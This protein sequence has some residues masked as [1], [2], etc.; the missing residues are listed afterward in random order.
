ML[1]NF[2]AFALMFGLFLSGFALFA[3]RRFTIH[4]HPFGPKEVGYLYAYSGL[5]GV[6][7]Q[8]GL[9]GRLVK[10]FGEE[11]LTLTGYVCA[12]AGFIGL[13]F[14][15]PLAA[16]LLVFSFTA[17]GNSVLRPCLTALVTHRS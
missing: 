11:R 8:G 3:E 4:G 10:R 6:F 12:A 16:L 13:A 2:F 5:L 1:L 15:H 9:L 17:F 7:I 14:V